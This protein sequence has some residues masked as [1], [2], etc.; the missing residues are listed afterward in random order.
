MIGFDSP[1]KSN[2]RMR[3]GEEITTAYGI[4]VGNWVRV[5]LL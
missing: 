4:E 3:Y 2:R 5:G 1:W